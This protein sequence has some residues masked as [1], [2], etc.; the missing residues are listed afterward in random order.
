MDK[1]N[2]KGRKKNLK[3]NKQTTKSLLVDGMVLLVD[4][5]ALQKYI[6]RPFS[7]REQKRKWKNKQIERGKKKNNGGEQKTIFC[8]FH[9]NKIK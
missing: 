8:W 3:W 5:T 7:K 6:Q 4:P 2:N 1:S 9:R